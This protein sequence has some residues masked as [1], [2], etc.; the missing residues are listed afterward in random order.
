MPNSKLGAKSFSKDSLLP[1][2]HDFWHIDAL[3]LQPLLEHHHSHPSHDEPCQVK[4]S[5]LW[6]PALRH[7]I[8]EVSRLF[9]LHHCIHRSRSP[10]ILESLKKLSCWAIL[11]QSFYKQ[12]SPSKSAY[13]NI[14][15]ECFRRVYAFY[16]RKWSIFLW[17]CYKQKGQLS[18]WLHVSVVLCIFELGH[19]KKY[20]LFTG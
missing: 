17:V 2:N 11:N 8:E 20:Q 19:A 9:S 16:C 1:E 4:L 7:L 18:T 14:G 15:K 3:P 12:R 10:R 6:H 13:C 5:A